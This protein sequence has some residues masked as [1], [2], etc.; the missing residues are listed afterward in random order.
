[1]IFRRENFSIRLVWTLFT[2][3]ALMKT[4]IITYFGWPTGP[5]NSYD[6]AANYNQFEIN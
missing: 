6:N 5:T 4:S 3:S 1:M 2:G